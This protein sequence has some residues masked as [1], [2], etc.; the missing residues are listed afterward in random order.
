[1]AITLSVP[2]Y[3]G[4]TGQDGTPDVTDVKV[5]VLGDCLVLG[6][7]DGLPHSSRMPPF[8]ASDELCLLP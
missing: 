3:R 2:G 4:P 6:H 1:M 8:D 7:L 5:D